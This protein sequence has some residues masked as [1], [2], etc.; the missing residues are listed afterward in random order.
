MIVSEIIRQL[1]IIKY[2]IKVFRKVFLWKW[3]FDKKCIPE[4]TLCRYMLIKYNIVLKLLCL[5]VYLEG[6]LIF[7]YFNQSK[8]IR[9]KLI[10]II[11]MNKNADFVALSFYSYHQRYY[12]VKLISF[13]KA[14]NFRC[15]RYR[16]EKHKTGKYIWTNMSVMTWMMLLWTFKKQ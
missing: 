8:I 7:T 10:N 5:N 3:F 6:I 11:I 2:I 4:E 9:V 14:L 12:A 16:F 13:I 15:Q 1:K